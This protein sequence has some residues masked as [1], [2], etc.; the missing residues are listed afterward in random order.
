M[1]TGLYLQSPVAQGNT[2]QTCK[3]RSC[4]SYPSCFSAEGRQ[5]LVRQITAN[6]LLGRKPQRLSAFPTLGPSAAQV[7]QSETAQG[8]TS[9]FQ[10]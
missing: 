10:R 2:F 3:I 6:V 4:D 7:L 8:K 1:D 9:A 5:G